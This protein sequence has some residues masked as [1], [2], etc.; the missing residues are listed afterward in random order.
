[1]RIGGKEDNERLA[2]LGLVDNLAEVRREG[3]D[4]HVG[5]R[6]RREGVEKA[7]GGLEESKDRIRLGLY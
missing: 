3:L 2:E 1:M 6:A 7:D 5:L 4:G